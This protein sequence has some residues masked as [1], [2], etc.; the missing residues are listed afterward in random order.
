MSSEKSYSV[1]KEMFVT[2]AL[3]INDTFILKFGI[4]K[5][6]FRNPR[7]QRQMNHVMRQGT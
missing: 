3:H 5:A 1:V 4:S 7:L 6:L 2:T